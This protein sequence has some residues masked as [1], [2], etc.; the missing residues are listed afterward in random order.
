[1]KPIPHAVETLDLTTGLLEKSLN[2][3]FF[4][5][6]KIQLIFLEAEFRMVKKYI[7][8]IIII[9]THYS[10]CLP[11]TVLRTLHYNVNPHNNHNEGNAISTIPFCT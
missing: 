8:L 10:K 4:K 5:K 6:I 3:T 7:I 11:V 9:S 2:V 1:M